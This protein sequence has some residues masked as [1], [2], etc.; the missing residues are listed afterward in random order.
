M[1]F[2]SLD[3]ADYAF[4]E[5]RA[6]EARGLLAEHRPAARRCVL[7]SHILPQAGTPLEGKHGQEKQLARADSER[8]LELVDDFDVDLVLGG[9]YHGYAASKR[10]RATILLTGGGGA[11]LD[12][13]EEFHHFLRLT[14][15]EKGVAHEVVKVDAKHG[16]EWLQ[17]LGLRYAPVPIGSLAAAVAAS[18]LAARRLRPKAGT[19]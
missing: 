19:A 13:P 9:H 8:I 18:S 10:G 16:L 1:L 2:V 4:D 11:S 7:L 5:R 14:L 17:Y 12:G 6:K 3:T 15:G